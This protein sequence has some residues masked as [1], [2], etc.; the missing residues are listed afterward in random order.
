MRPRTH[1]PKISASGALSAPSPRVSS[2]VV[3]GPVLKLEDVVVRYGDCLAIRAASVALEPGAI[4]AIVGENGAGKSTL[5]KVA[6][7]VSSPRRAGEGRADRSSRRRAEADPAR[8]RA[9]CTSTSCSSAAFTALENLV[10]GAEPTRSFG[11]L[12][13][14]RARRE[15]EKLMER[16]GLSVSARRTRRRRSPSASGSGSRS[17]ACS[18]AA[19]ARCCSTSRR[20]CSRRSRRSSSTRRS[21]RL[22]EEGA[23]VVVVTHR[24][25]EVIRFARP[26]DRDAARPRGR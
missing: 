23:T 2:P 11:R 19:R 20:R 24:L 10:L 13:L 25:D 9:W 17:C 1:G 14:A 22:A 16:T 3:R 8:R 12:D 15:A 18:T 21:R 5:L 7:G 26:G 4:H 6:A